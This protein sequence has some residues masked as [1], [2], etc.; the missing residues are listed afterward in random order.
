M[1]LASIPAWV[2]PSLTSRW[3]VPRCEVK[4]CSGAI[5][6]PKVAP[7][8]KKQ[9]ALN[10]PS[11]GKVFEWAMKAE[12]EQ[13]PA[14]P[15][16]RRPDDQKLRDGRC[17]KLAAKEMTTAVGVSESQREGKASPAKPLEG[18]GG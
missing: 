4:R 6:Q 2:A 12:Q 3:I 15:M 7:R 16:D 9:R 10:L 11:R 1:W 8:K 5:V 17:S 14:L 13:H 18:R